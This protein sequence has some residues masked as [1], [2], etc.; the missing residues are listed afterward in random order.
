MVLATL[1]ACAHGIPT[2]AERP[3]W[4][5]GAHRALTTPEPRFEAWGASR[6]VSGRPQ[7]TEVADSLARGNLSSLVQHYADPLVSSLTLPGARDGAGGVCAPYQF[8]GGAVVERSADESGYVYARAQTTFAEVARSLTRWHKAQ[9]E[10][11]CLTRNPQ[12]NAAYWARALQ[13]AFDELATTTRR[14]SVEEL[15]VASRPKVTE[16]SPSPV[17]TPV[18][19]PA[20][21]KGP[22]RGRQCERTSERC[23]RCADIS[24]PAKIPCSQTSPCSG[25]CVEQNGAPQCLATGEFCCSKPPCDRPPGCDAA[26]SCGSREAG[27]PMTSCTFLSPCEPQVVVGSVLEAP[28][29][30]PCASWPAVSDYRDTE[31]SS[32]DGACPATPLSWQIP[33]EQM[34]SGASDRGGP[35]LCFGVVHFD[36]QGRQT[37]SCGKYHCQTLRYCDGRAR[38]MYCT[39]IA[40]CEAGVARAVGFTW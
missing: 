28:E 1:A 2:H 11:G 30:P 33:A 7:S 16:P 34:A 5:C 38:D 39:V 17:P 32:A 27:G 9:I 29:P 22:P 21:P 26:S 4:A 35:G 18:P 40:K 20:V 15:A 36:S 3:T 8:D 6:S 37:R 24:F 19:S 13:R 25:V 10:N 12:V 31:R 14:C 23:W